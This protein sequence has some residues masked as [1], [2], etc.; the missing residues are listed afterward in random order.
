MKSTFWQ[1]LMVA[2]LCA[3][4]VLQT[5]RA[6]TKEE[7]LETWAMALGGRKNLQNAQ[8]I[9]IRGTVETGGVKGTYERWSTSRG[10]FRTAL[11]LP[12]QSAR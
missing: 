10:E 6:Q 11:D 12:G 3:T 9:H 2:L 8:T 5:T 7:A 1:V 4:G